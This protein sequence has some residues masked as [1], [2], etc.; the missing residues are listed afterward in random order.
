[1]TVDGCPNCK[2]R[3]VGVVVIGRNEG[4]RLVTCL[5]SVPDG[6]PV[7]YVDS[8]SKDGSVRAAQDLGVEV[9]QLDL[10]IPFTAARARNIGLRRLMHIEPSVRFVQFV[11]ADCELIPGW[12]E[13]AVIFLESR[14]EIAAVCGR[15]R[16]RHPEKSIYNWLCSVEWD[17][18][19]AEINAC[20]GIA[21]FSVPAFQ[22]VDG[23]RDSMIAGEESE[24]CLRL[25]RA[26]LKIWR[27]D[28][29]MA[30]H[31][32]AMTRFSEW[33]RRSKRSG[34]AF[35]LGADLHGAGPEYHWVWESRRAVIWGLLIPGGC[36]LAM[37]LL[38]WWGVA[39]WLVYV[40]QIVRLASRGRRP[41]RERVWLAIF[42]VL[43]RFPEALG[44][45]QFRWNRMLKRQAGLIEY[46]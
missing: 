5:R 35:A 24:I 11:D 46:K 19:V 44:Y 13:N 33:W 42:Q 8:N 37:I 21:L 39:A 36:F 41:I 17:G 10:S 40:F 1:M 12:I 27:L 6:L 29:E 23:F 3:V 14:P 26:G 31:D 15:L 2:A 45:I 7:I 9:V 22:A 20:G 32:A 38:G 43:S 28:L 25:R 34:Y 18:P 16:E 30:L 4:L